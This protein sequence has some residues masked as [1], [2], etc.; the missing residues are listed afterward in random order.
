MSAAEGQTIIKKDD[1]DLSERVR[2]VAIEFADV[3]QRSTKRRDVRSRSQLVKQLTD[4]C[5]TVNTLDGTSK[6]LQPAKM[7]PLEIY[8][9]SLTTMNFIQYW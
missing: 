2:R 4:T 5:F 1:E 6:A 7:P 8:E 3:L 9:S